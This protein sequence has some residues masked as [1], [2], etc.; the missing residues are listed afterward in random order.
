MRGSAVVVGVVLALSS[1]C[2]DPEAGFTA[3]SKR[4]AR[5][6]RDAG[7]PD[8]GPR[9]DAGPCT[10]TPGFVQGDYLLAISVSIAASK[11]IVLLDTVSTPPLNGGTGVSFDA[12]PLSYRDRKTPVGTKVALGPFFV[13]SNGNFTASIP[14]LTVV[15]DANPITVGSEIQADV[16]LT[17]N[18]CGNGSFFCGTVSGTASRPITLDLSGSTFTLTRVEGGNIPT[19]PAI[20][21]AGKPS[22]PPPG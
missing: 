5:T 12:Q 16:T 2:A 22:D 18:L 11:P 7:V 14:G 9:V 3:F 8:A 10:V 1:G 6:L 13:D 15:G 19:Q 21:C 17:G 20:D 4:L